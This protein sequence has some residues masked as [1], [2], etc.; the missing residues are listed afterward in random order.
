MPVAMVAVVAAA[1][2]ATVDP[3]GIREFVA[4]EIARFKAPRAVAVVE[5]VRRHANG[6]PDYGWAK[7]VALTASDVTAAANGS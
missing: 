3:P 1:T 5:R 2:G 7:E 4:A 6:K